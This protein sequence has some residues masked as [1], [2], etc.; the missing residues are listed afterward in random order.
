MT[1]E[2]RWLPLG[3]SEGTLSSGPSAA[4]FVREGGRE[5]LNTEGGRRW[6]WFERWKRRKRFWSDEGSGSYC[7]YCT[8]IE[9]RESGVVRGRE[10]NGRSGVVA[11]LQTDNIGKGTLVGRREG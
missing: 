2:K 3:R 5:R 6:R 10:R 1:V 4:C 8:G 11:K 9:S 7:S